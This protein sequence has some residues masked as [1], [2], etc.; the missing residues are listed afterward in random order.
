MSTMVSTNSSYEEQDKFLHGL[1]AFAI[2][3]I[4]TKHT[5]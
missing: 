2:V 5:F 4:F 3:L 1:Y